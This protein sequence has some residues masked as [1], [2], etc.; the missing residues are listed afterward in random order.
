MN[1]KNFE[2]DDHI[3]NTV[4]KTFFLERISDIKYEVYTK[5]ELKNMSLVRSS[6][7]LEICK[8]KYNN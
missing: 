3:Y 2:N 8:K 5:D 1:N 7:E 4:I 6:K